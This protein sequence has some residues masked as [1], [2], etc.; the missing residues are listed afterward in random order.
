M[1][2]FT[3][4]WIILEVVLGDPEQ[5]ERLFRGYPNKLSIQCTSLS[6][7]YTPGSFFCFCSVFSKQRHLV[8][9]SVCALCFQS[10][11][12]PG[13]FH[14]H[15]CNLQATLC[16][17]LCMYACGRMQFAGNHPSSMHAHISRVGQNHMSIYTAHDFFT[18]RISGI[19]FP[20]GFIRF[21]T[22]YGVYSL[23]AVY[24][25]V[26]RNLIHPI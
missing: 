20:T 1:G 6:I 10:R 14:A 5:F 25:D 19:W 16:P 22:V 17:C 7:R 4:P 21:R 2:N 12:S 24:M 23:Y 9:S 15:V 26:Y 18:A 3:T 13:S 11:G 8:A